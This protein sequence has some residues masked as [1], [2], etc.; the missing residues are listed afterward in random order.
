MFKHHL[1]YKLYDTQ[2]NQP[3]R[4]LALSGMGFGTTTKLSGCSPMHTFL[5]NQC[6]Q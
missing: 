2:R 6:T 5:E 1:P 3:L 4:A